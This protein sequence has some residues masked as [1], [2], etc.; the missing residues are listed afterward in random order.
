MGIL[1]DV[2]NALDRWA[3]WRRIRA[4]PDR[5]DGLDARLA[6]L[7]EKLGGKWPGDVCK[8]CG[9][10]ALRLRTSFPK[11]KGLVQQEWTCTICGKA[12]VRVVKP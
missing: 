9:E 8:S 7:E 4:A 5:L 1:E 10:R 6:V 12:E 3:E 2:L 11:D